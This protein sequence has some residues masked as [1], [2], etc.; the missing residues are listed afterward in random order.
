MFPR[1]FSTVAG[2]PAADGSIHD[3]AYRG[4]ENAFG[5]PF[6]FTYASNTSMMVAVSLL[7]RYA[8]FVKALGGT[9]WNL[10]WIAGVGVVGSLMMRL[11]QGV[12][13][14]TYG[15]RKVWLW[16]SIMVAVSLLGHLAIGRV[17]TPAIYVLRILFNTSIA[18]FFGASIT[19][20]AGQAPVARMAE[21]IGSLGTSG[22]VGMMLG[23]SLGDV[24]LGGTST[25]RS[26]LNHMFEMAGLLAATSFVFAWL[27]TR[28][29]TPPAKRR[30][31]PT[32]WLLR[33]YHP[34][35]VLLCGV[36]MGF[37]LGLPGIFL[38]PFTASLGIPGIAVFFWVYAP[39]AFVMRL[40]S[41]RFPER[42]G[43]RPMILVGMAALVSGILSF[44]LVEHTWQLV[45][46]AVLMG[47]AHAFLF[48][49]VLAGG[50]SAFPGRNRGLGTT[51]MLAMFDVG[52][53]IGNPT[54]GGLLRLA[55]ITGL[56]PY[57]TMFLVI[58]AVLVVAAITYVWFSR[59]AKA[60][61]QVVATKS[62][63]SHAP[64]PEPVPAVEV[65][66]N[67]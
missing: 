32:L 45:A 22:F 5:R 3:T 47:C 21:V 10:G 63:K 57:P 52:N 23:T 54:A 24:L 16:S 7:F 17:D 48:P 51:L 49:A 6:W 14:D 8:D 36:A 29:S 37:G 56:A 4:S 28:G 50:S 25:D 62:L 13:I 34:G 19:F 18:G 12:G 40:S 33:R 64:P 41:R 59:G 55:R 43:I 2:E 35:A 26:E 67:R 1:L 61:E 11:A 58:A 66:S 30:R 9:E 27:A 60:A 38:R 42:Y 15:P 44:L 46:P 53:L 65:G 39:T 31:L 20:V